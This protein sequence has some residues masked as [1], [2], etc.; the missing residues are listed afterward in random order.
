MCRYCA[1]QER[2]IKEVRDK[3]RRLDTNEEHMEY[4]ITYLKEENF[5]NETRYAEAYV[6][7]KLRHKKWGR[8]KII[9]MLRQQGLDEQTIQKAL[10]EALEVDEEEQILAKLLQKRLSLISD[11]NKV[12]RWALQRGFDPE[13]IK[14]HLNM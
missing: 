11:K 2:S 3:L 14:K 8:R 12:F 1:Y 5:L 7:G 13:E 6:R 4:I 9:Y 10:N